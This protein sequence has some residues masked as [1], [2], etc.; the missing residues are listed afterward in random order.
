M[1]KRIKTKIYRTIEYFFVLVVRSQNS[2]TEIRQLYCTYTT[3][4][5]LLC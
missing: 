4:R 2:A 1:F 5:I 3:I